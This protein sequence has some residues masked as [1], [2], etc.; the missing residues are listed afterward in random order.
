MISKCMNQPK[1]H[2]Y[3]CLGYMLEVCGI[4]LRAFWKVLGGRLFG[5]FEGSFDGLFEKLV[6]K[7]LEGVWM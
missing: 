4:C 7:V 3:T 2:V 5:A 6:W 1:L